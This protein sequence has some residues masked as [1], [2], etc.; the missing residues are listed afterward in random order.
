MTGEEGQGSVIGG[1]EPDEFR[2]VDGTQK[3]Y[4]KD[5]RA[6]V[7]REYQARRRE[8]ALQR[9]R[10]RKST[11]LQTDEPSSVCTLDTESAITSTSVQVVETV[12]DLRRESAIT[13]VQT[14]IVPDPTCRVPTV[15]AASASILGTTEREAYLVNHCKR[16]CPVCP[17]SEYVVFTR[18][19]DELSTETS[20]IKFHPL[21]DIFRPFLA[22]DL[23]VN[24]ACLYASNH[25]C[26]LRDETANEECLQI[27]GKTVELLRNRIED[28]ADDTSILTVGS[29]IALDVELWPEVRIDDW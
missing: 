9:R 22:E 1:G 8:R 26:K 27:L 11:L 15:E 2:F 6:H 20:K 24:V 17:V 28:H 12:S 23:G 18:I 3:A 13:I 19:I 29:L 14:T 25:I 10:T 16:T 5:V 21:R 7:L 4:S